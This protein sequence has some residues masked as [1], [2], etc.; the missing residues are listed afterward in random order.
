MVDPI[1]RPSLL[2]PLTLYRNYFTRAEMDTFC[3][4]YA[5]VLGPYNIEPS[6]TASAVKPKEVINQ[7]YDAAQEGV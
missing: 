6:N 5:A 1:N 4:R 3:G 7:I 2:P